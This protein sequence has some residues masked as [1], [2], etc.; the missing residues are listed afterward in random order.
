MIISLQGSY[1]CGECQKGYV[2]NQSMGC[3]NS[4]D[5]CPDGTRCDTNAHCVLKG[6]QFYCQVIVIL[7]TRKYAEFCHQDQ[8]MKFHE[9]LYY[10]INTKPLR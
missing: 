2:G 4:P 3:H 8:L 10:K 6:S 9:L 7:S 1:I 5:L